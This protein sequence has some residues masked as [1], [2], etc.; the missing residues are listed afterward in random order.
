MRANVP[1]EI[2]DKRKIDHS[3]LVI[4]L[5]FGLEKSFQPIECDEPIKN[6]RKHRAIYDGNKLNSI[7]GSSFTRHR[8]NCT[9]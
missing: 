1:Y 5:P 8:Q 6:I 2:I 4:Y 9:E 3:L 7:E